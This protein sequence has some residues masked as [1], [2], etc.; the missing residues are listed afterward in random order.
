MKRTLIVMSAVLLASANLAMAQIQTAGDMVVSLDPENF[1]PTSGIWANIC[2]DCEGDFQASGAPALWATSEGTP[3]IN[4]NGGSDFF[5]GPNA[6]FGLTGPDQTRSIEVWAFNPE[7][8]SE[9]TLVS[10]G[11]R[12]GDAGTNMSFNYGNHQNFGAVGHWGAPD[13]GWIDQD[14]TL[15]L[16]HI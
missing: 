3:V 16:I 11:Q 5:T 6:T 7:I 4:F 13:L 9:E 1:D 15:S 8:A 14:T 10:W 12:G 2:D